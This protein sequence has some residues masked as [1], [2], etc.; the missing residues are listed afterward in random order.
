[1]IKLKEFD[2]I[3]AQM[4]LTFVRKNH[5]YGDDNISVLGEKGIYV[6]MWD[7]MSRLKQLLWLAKKPDVKNESLID[8]LLDLATYAIICVIFLRGK[9]K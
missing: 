2:N 7:K 8:T 6:R 5:D 9:W 3:I 4:R 1:M